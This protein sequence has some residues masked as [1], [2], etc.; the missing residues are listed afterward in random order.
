MVRLQ[1]LQIDKT[2]AAATVLIGSENSER[3]YVKRFC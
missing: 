1:G 3:L 2:S